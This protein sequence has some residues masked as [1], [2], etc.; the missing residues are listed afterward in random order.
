VTDVP[1]ENERATEVPERF[2]PGWMQGQM[3]EAEHLVRYSWASQFAAGTRVLDAGC[4][5]AY[6]STLLA[7]AGARE[8]VGV[9]K[10]KSIIAELAPSL[11]SNVSLEVGDVTSL[12]FE[13]DS[14]DLV[15][16]FEV[17]E[18]VPNP[19][20]VLDE[21]KRV[22]RPGG[23]LVVS[24]PNRDVY[25]PGNPYHLREL[26]PNELESLLSERFTHARVW[27]QHTWVASGIFDDDQFTT[28]DNGLIEPVELRKLAHDT[29]AQ[30]TYT[31][32]LAGDGELPLGRGT[33]ALTSDV[34]LRHWSALWHEQLAAIEELSESRG[35]LYELRRQLLASESELSRMAELEA[36]AEELRTVARLYAEVTNSLSWRITKPLRR[37]TAL[38]RTGREKGLAEV[39]AE[40]DAARARK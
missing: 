39:R 26:T 9:D 28:A 38:I 8:V 19:G 3:V 27:R 17:I 7:N 18:H 11:P 16:C 29:L 37:A 24:T 2:E 4:G 36:S 20:A 6:G 15:V 12:S 35:E 33:V 40:I 1:T 25:M 32:G 34:D 13:A 21:L 31:I 10:D 23:L 30:E 14:F 22:L 5:M